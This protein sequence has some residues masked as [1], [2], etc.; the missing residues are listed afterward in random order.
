MLSLI[1]G[2]TAFVLYFLYD[3][4]SFTRK[5]PFV[6]SFFLLGTLLLGAATAMDLVAC[7]RLRAFSGPGDLLLL[8]GSGLSFLALIY[9]LFFALPFEKTYTTQ[10]TG[11]RVY[12]GG[13]YAL[14]R[15]PGILCFFF[16]Y[17]TLGLAALPGRLLL[18][19]MIFSLLNLLYAWFQDRVTFPKTFCDYADYRRRVPFLIPTIASIR[20]ARN[21]LLHTTHR[22]DIL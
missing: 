20:M 7:I 13:A 8:A 11:S 10:E 1:L 15:H 5:N 14:C 3:I 9:C 16:L 18:H 12:D 2:I 4:N 19:G 21:T 6:H 17:L 22:E